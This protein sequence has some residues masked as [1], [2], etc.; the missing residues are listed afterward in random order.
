[1]PYGMPWNIDAIICSSCGTES[2]HPTSY[3]AH[4]GARVELESEASKDNIRSPITQLDDVRKALIKL[5]GNPVRLWNYSVSHCE[6]QLRVYPPTQDDQKNNVVI[7]CADTRLIRVPTE[8]WALNLR[9]EK[10]EDQYGE[11][12]VLSDEQADVRI[13]CGMIGVYHDMEAK[14]FGV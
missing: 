13:V 12:Y 10:T 4:C 5:G 1:M 8:D 6:L 9:L 7:M 2:L 14:F 3:C 11:L